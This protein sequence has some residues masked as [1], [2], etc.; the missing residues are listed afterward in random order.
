MPPVL[1]VKNLCKVYYHGRKL[2]SAVDNVSFELKKGEILG[3][4]GPNGSGKT[5]IIQMLLG[6]LLTTSGFIIY[7]KKAFETHRSEILQYVSFASSY[8]SLPWLLSI[9][10][11]LEILGRLYGFTPSQS[12]KRF[13]PLLDRFGILDK[14]N[15]PVSS[16]S[17]GQITRLMLVKAFFIEPKVVLL[18]EPTASLDLDISKEICEFIFE[19]REKTGLSIIFTSHRMEEA[20]IL[21]D[22]IIFLKEGKIIADD[23]PKKLVQSISPFRL[24]LVMNEGIKQTV[25]LAEKNNLPYQIEPRSIEILIEESEIPSF[26]DSLSRFGVTYVNIKIKEPSLADYFLQMTR[27]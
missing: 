10:E 5:T 25:A 13:D 22:R 24:K 27:K 26:L 23:I 3:L 11:N 2:Y 14:K 15:A 9:A 18:D 17:A 6:T 16:L 1:S 7:F 8:N 21:C 4:L 19:Q 12:R 20:D